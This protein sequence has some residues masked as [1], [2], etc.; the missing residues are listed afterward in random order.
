MYVTQAGVGSR[1][2]DPTGYR[3]RAAAIDS[4]GAGQTRIC[5]SDQSPVN[6]AISA[7]VLPGAFGWCG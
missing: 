2:P 6:A 3:T 4:A 1:W 7:L 5:L